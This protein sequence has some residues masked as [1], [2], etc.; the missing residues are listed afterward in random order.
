MLM[1]RSVVSSSFLAALLLSVGVLV[2]ANEVCDQ[3]NQAILSYFELNS[4]DAA[5][6]NP[7]D[8]VANNFE[9]AFGSG[10]DVTAIPSVCDIDLANGL[11]NCD[12]DFTSAEN[13]D[14]LEIVTQVQTMCSEVGGQFYEYNSSMECVGTSSITL[15]AQIVAGPVCIGLSCD[16]EE[17]SAD[18]NELQKTLIPTYLP[19]F[20][21]S[22]SESGGS[23]SSG[24]EATTEGEEGGVDDGTEGGE[25]GETT[26]DG[27]DA[28][29]GDGAGDGTDGTTDGSD[30]AA[31]NGSINAINQ[32]VS[33]G[34]SAAVPGV[35]MNSVAVAVMAV[36]YYML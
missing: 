29:D 21:T 8:G 3:E 22:C 2:Q 14:L 6:T 11:V 25:G 24:S 34:A 26:T 23:S 27:G 35:L 20:F 17:V 28:T 18:L 13:T 10:L 30:G 9:A 7:V 1:N 36:S 32:Q 12:Y 15:Q 33:S 16:Q 5:A 4:P 31:G 19:Q